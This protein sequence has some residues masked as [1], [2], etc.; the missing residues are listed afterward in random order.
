MTVA[1]LIDILKEHSPSATVVLWGPTACGKHVSK[2]R[3][4]EVQALQLGARERNGSL[5]LEM[6]AEGDAEL[7]GPSPGVVLGGQ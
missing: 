1:D 5:L 3:F 4:D 6:W 7:Q 2:L